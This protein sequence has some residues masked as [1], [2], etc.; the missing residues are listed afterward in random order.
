M[1]ESEAPPATQRRGY[2]NSQSPEAFVLKN[3]QFS[4]THHE[5]TIAFHINLAL[6]I[7]NDGR[8]ESY[9]FEMFSAVEASIIIIAICGLATPRSAVNTL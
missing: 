7:L 4:I 6:D 1:L 3:G 5:L 8:A 2:R 9:M